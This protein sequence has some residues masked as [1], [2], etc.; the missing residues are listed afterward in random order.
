MESVNSEHKTEAK[1][2]NYALLSKTVAYY[3]CVTLFFVVKSVF[4]NFTLLANLIGKL[5]HIESTATKKDIFL[6]YLSIGGVRFMKIKDVT[7]A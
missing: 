6:V 7:Y 1:F 4:K 3:N 5:L 2:K